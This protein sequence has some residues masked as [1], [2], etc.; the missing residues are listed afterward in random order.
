MSCSVEYRGEMFIIGGVYNPHRISKVA[1]CK[2]EF[3]D[4]LPGGDEL[5]FVQHMCTVFNDAIWICG[6]KDNDKDTSSI[7]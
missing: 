1:D 2:L 7:N 4:L 3:Y 6:R 5:E